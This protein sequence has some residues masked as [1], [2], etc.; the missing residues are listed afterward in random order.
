M[1]KMRCIVPLTTSAGGVFSLGANYNGDPS[2]ASAT[3]C[4]ISNG[5]TAFTFTNATAFEPVWDQMRCAGLAF[6]FV[7]SAPNEVTATATY[8]PIFFDHDR[9]G[10]ESAIGSWTQSDFLESTNMRVKNALRPWK[11]YRKSIK[12]RMY[13]KIPAL[14]DFNQDTPPQPNQN[15]WGQWHSATRSQ[16]QTDD[17]RGCHVGIFMTGGAASFTYG[18]IIVTGYFVYKDLIQ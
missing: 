9:D 7:P 3:E 12:Y 17:A 16:F 2:T 8:A 11:Y 5:T 6:K 1:I 18:N 14:T 4:V 13:N 15:L 10:L